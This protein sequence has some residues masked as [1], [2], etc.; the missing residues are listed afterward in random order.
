MKTKSGLYSISLL[1]L[2]SVTLFSCKKDKTDDPEPVVKASQITF[3]GSTYA[4]DKGVYVYWSKK[5]TG[6]MITLI[7]LSPGGQFHSTTGTIDSISGTG[8]GLAFNCYSSDSLSIAAGNYVYNN[9][10]GN[11]SGTFEGANMVL[12]YDFANDIGEEV[13]FNGGTLSVAKSG[14]TFEI[15]YSGQDGMGNAMTFYYKG[16]IPGYWGIW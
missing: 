3:K 15:S 13:E 2:L 10:G 5:D 9:T 8:T 12:N 4:I 14:T 7:F 1:L 16:L 6:S 11:T